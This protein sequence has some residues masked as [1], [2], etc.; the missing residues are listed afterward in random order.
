MVL[1]DQDI[2]K[3]T[4]F[5]KKEPQT[6]QEIS[7]LI[8]KSWVTT[9]SYLNQIKERTGLIDIKTFRGGTKAALKIVFYNHAG[10]L[11]TDDLKE[12]LYN[13]IKNGRKKIDFDFL[14]IYQFIPDRKKR[15]FFEDYERE[16][17]TNIISFLRQATNQVYIFSGNLSF[18]NLK[19]KNNSILSVI[20]EL[21]KRKVNIKILCRINIASLGNIN[22]IL[23]LMAKYP[24]F[25][26]IKH[27]YQPL[28][29]TIID[30]KIARFK[31][32]ECL[33]TYKKDE[34]NKDTRVIYEFHDSE[35]VS[36]MQKVF[37]NLFRFS[38]D[39]NKRMKEIKKII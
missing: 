33:T 21:V 26:E 22:N 25:I 36:W 24:D 4:D 20:E 19:E 1:N 27:C 12:N 38:I 31:D 17:I 3:I 37:W 10:S 35:W 39:H 8:K 9:D 7:K 13:L 11:A 29:G 14:E 34:L 5:V 2:K 28:R 18:M 6:V 15:A 32:E 23:T 30:D 16:N